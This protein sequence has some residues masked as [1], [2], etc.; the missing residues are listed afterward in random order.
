MLSSSLSFIRDPFWSPVERF[1]QGGSALNVDRPLWKAEQHALRDPEP[2]RKVDALLLCVRYAARLGKRA[3][4]LGIAARVTDA[5]GALGPW[6]RDYRAATTIE[7]FLEELDA[8]E[9]AKRL[10]RLVHEPDRRAEVCIL[11][12]SAAVGTED[13]EPWIDEILD[14]CGNGSIDEPK[15]SAFIEEAELLKCFA[16]RYGRIAA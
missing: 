9:E 14:A 3:E 6:I 13:V 7:Y 11:I 16:A 12:G 5:I 2:R 1:V 4:A 10:A 8:F 15:R